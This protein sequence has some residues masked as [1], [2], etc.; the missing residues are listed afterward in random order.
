MNQEY[1]KLCIKEAKKSL[2]TDDVPV[3]AIIIKDD[4]II[5][6]SHNCREKNK[7]ITGHAEIKCIEKANKKN[8]SWRLDECVMYTTLEPCLMCYEAIIQSRI[9]K[10]YFFAENDL[11]GFHNHIKNNDKI[12]DMFIFIKNDEYI[13]LLKKFF[14]NK[15][16]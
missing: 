6:K 16:K 8:K 11:F 12:N 9:K 13:E 1:M 7:I 4:K 10:V 2:K 5:S 14:K 3:G 15:R